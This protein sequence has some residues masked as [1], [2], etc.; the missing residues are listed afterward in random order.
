MAT[1][2]LL[3]L[4]AVAAT[5]PSEGSD[6]ESIGA[7]A[8]RRAFVPGSKH[9]ATESTHTS[10]LAPVLIGTHHKTGTVLLSKVFRSA[11]KY[12]GVPRVR[13]AQT[14]N[15]T[16]CGPYFKSQLPTVCIVE[17]INA[18]DVRAWAQSRL[19]PFIH[20]VREPLEMCISSYQYLLT[21]AEPWMTQPLRDLNG[22][23]LQQHYTAIGPVL[24]V[25][26]ECTRMMLELVETALIYNSTRSRARTATIRFEEFSTDYDG[27]MR[28][29]FNFLGTQTRYTEYLVN[30]S[31]A[32]DLARHPSPDPRHVSANFDKERLRQIVMRDPLMSKLFT[33]LRSILGYGSIAGPEPLRSELC[34]LMQKICARTHVGFM[35]WCTYGRVHLGR[36][37]SL[38]E[39]G[40]PSLEHVTNHAARSTFPSKSE[41]TFG[42][43]TTGSTRTPLR[44][45][46]S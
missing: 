29:M 22:S 27:T 33:G 30:I 13:E 23:T 16:Q 6:P 26:F 31:S 4:S 25:P 17:H 15:R 8:I 1:T 28:S 18:H 34:E 7:D 21:G 11:C 5:P 41:S 24:S 2:A 44:L 45:R 32:H 38:T 42:G 19:V 40:D 14:T 43:L 36:L 9:Q 12:M 37:P 39:C 10:W 46:S 3:I 20:T 35:H